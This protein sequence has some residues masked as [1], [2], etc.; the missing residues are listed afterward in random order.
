MQTTRRGLDALV[1]RNSRI[2]L[3]TNNRSSSP[4]NM[5][6]AKLVDQTGGSG[7]PIFNTPPPMPNPRLR[8][9]WL[10]P[11]CPV[12]A[13]SFLRPSRPSA[14][15]PCSFPSDHPCLPCCR[16]A[17][18]N[19]PVGG[20]FGYKAILSKLN[21]Y[22]ELVWVQASVVAERR[23]RDLQRPVPVERGVSRSIHLAHAARADED[24]DIVVAESGADVEGHEFVIWE[25]RPLDN[26]ETGTHHPSLQ[27]R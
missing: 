2:V 16:Y 12:S 24:G 5:M 4:I 10:S 8:R 13:S 26:L 1:N 7:N 20:R 6:P 25:N 22:L 21:A 9:V 14:S 11:V 19:S 18:E 15:G 23:R 27:R 17:S 3:S